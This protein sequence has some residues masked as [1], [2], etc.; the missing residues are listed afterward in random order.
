MICGA[1]SRSLAQTLMHPANTAKTILQSTPRGGL[2][3]AIKE[4]G[5]RALTR[6]AGAQF[7][8]SVPHGALNFA[9]LESTR[10]ILSRI[11]GAGGGE[12]NSLG[13]GLDFL[14]S[15]IATVCCSVVSTPQMMITDNIMAGNYPS[16]PKAVSGLAAT[17]GIQGFYTGWFPGPS[18]AL[19]TTSLV[20]NTR[21]VV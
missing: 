1:I 11:T 7:V 17:R 4:G 6:G 18:I 2:A 19:T 10:G 21:A 16:L 5:L 8:L 9:V 20:A 3:R 15:S 12:R 14:S 13:P